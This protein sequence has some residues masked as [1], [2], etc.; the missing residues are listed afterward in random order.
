M[1]IDGKVARAAELL[2]QGYT[3]EQVRR[4][5][6]VT[7]KDVADYKSRETNYLKSWTEAELKILAEYYPDHG[8]HWSGW[9]TLLPGRTYWSIKSKAPASKIYSKLTNGARR[10]T[11]AD[12]AALREH[13]PVHGSVWDGWAD[14][15]PG[16]TRKSIRG[17]ARLLGLHAPDCSAV[18]RETWWT[19][20]EIEKLRKFYP[21]N[22]IFW[23]GWEKELPGRSGLAI[24]TKAKSLG[25]EGA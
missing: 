21:I 5:V 20:E 10:W 15:L 19:G 7:N 4:M 2:K 11:D 13:Y 1:S 24:I 18:S 9:K 14:S 16:R 23:Q 3:V 22:G 12:V 17:K 6:G 8:P 25:I